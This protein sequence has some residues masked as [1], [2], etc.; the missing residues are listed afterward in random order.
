MNR[1]TKSAL[2]A[3]SLLMVIFSALLLTACGGNNVI[4]GKEVAV[5]YKD[6]KAAVKFTPSK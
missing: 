3:L 5:S 4:D 2:A 6:W 1:I